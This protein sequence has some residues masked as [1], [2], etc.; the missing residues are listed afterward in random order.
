MLAQSPNQATSWQAEAMS[1]VTFALATELEQLGRTREWNQATIGCE[2]HWVALAVTRQPNA[3]QPTEKDDQRLQ[4]RHCQ[5]TLYLEQRAA[6]PVFSAK[7]KALLEYLM[8]RQ[9]ELV[10]SDRLSLIKH[11]HQHAMAVMFQS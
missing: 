1:G 2:V 10:G 3:Q 7:I 8:A 6:E 9:Q 4:G 11:D 5:T